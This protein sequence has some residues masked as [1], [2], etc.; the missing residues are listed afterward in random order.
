MSGAAAPQRRRR[1]GKDRARRPRIGLALAGGGPLGG[2]YEIGAL[3]AL[4]ESLDGLEVDDL[5]AYVGVSSGG[6]VA[7]AL[8]APRRLPR[9]GPLGRW[10]GRP[11][12]PLPPAV[13]AR[14]G[15][16]GGGG[17]ARRRPGLL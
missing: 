9:I 5:D 16:G 1:G 3:L 2:I 12:V 14:S 10:P 13:P 6:F 8:A 11:R 4:S 17:G 15:R 7:A